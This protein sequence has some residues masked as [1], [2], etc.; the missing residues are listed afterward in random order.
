MKVTTLKFD[1]IDSTNS[2]AISQA[3]LGAAEGLCVI[4]RQQTDGRGRHGRVWVSPP[5]AGLYLSMVLRPKLEMQYI[6]LITLAGGIAVYETLGG[7]GVH[8]DIKW[9]NDVL[10]DGRKIAGILGE[11]T[12]TPAGVAVVLGIGVNVANTSFPPVIAE[13]AT[14]LNH[15]VSRV[16]IPSQLAE[17]LI[18]NVCLFYQQLLADGGPRTIIDEWGRRSTYFK[19]KAVKV[20]LEGGIVLGV[21]DGL[22]PSGALRVVTDEG[23]V[24]LIQAGHVEL[25]REAEA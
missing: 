2:E 25:L 12:D 4:A 10:V 5:D 11:T 18:N 1:T 17:P 24:R 22:E 23:S 9:V 3:R 16:A 19:G 13:K 8:A 14:A 7:L 20:I 21:T 15:H 6:P